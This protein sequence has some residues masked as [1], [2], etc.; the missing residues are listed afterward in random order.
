MDVWITCPLCG[1]RW[2]E[3]NSPRCHH[4]DKEYAERRANM[5]VHEDEGNRQQRRARQAARLDVSAATVCNSTANTENLAHMTKQPGPNCLQPDACR[6]SPR[7]TH[8]ASCHGKARM[9]AM[10]AQPGFTARVSAAGADRMRGN[11]EL[12][13]KAAN[14][15]HTQYLSRLGVKPSEEADYRALRKKGFPSPEAASVII[16]S[17]RD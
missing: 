12:A 17:R 16:N 4:S 2:P 14:A 5:L 15:R 13:A 11:A 7:N 9:K 1:V 6:A 10:H 3:G 8:C